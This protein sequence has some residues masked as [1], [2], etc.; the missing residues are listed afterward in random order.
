[1]SKK[2]PDLMEKIV[3]LCKRRG[4]V[5]PGSEIY[6]GFAGTYDYGHYGVL[7]KDHLKDAWIRSMRDQDNIA[8]IDSSIFSSRQVWEA[9]GHVSGFSDPLVIC[10]SCHTRHRADHL[11]EA[12]G[13]QA[14]EKMSEKK[15]NEIFDAH[16]KELKCSVCGKKDFGTVQA[17][18]LM[19]TSTLGKFEEGDQD[20]FL[21][22]ET[23]Q[24]IYI[25]Y[26]NI[27]DT[28]I[29]SI[30]F[31]IAQVGK[32]FRN[33]ISPRQF[34]FR[35]REFEQMEMQYFVNPKDASIEYERWK[36][37]R[38]SYYET[39][40]I[41]KDKLRWKQH[42]NLVF[43]AKDAWDI[44]YEYPFG[45]NELEGL[46]NRGDYDL[47]Q[48]QKFSGVD[49]S[50]FDEETKERFIPHVIEASVGLD[51]TM[52]MVLSDAYDEDEMNGQKRVVLRFA[53]NIAPIRAGV[54]PLLRNKSQLVEKAREVYR[55]LKKEFGNIIFDNNGNIGKRY[56]RQDEIGTPFCITIDFDTLTDDTVTL[57]DRD[58][59]EQKR[60]K[61]ADLKEAIV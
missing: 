58:T 53:K 7:L 36:N 24:G 49:M 19:A 15:L 39:I 2:D 9:S 45:W 60:I 26:K 43:Y 30:P 54:F 37:Q 3:S 6:G 55:E 59:G 5:Y 52:L 51:R 1:M 42:E 28:G 61:V 50:Y 32:V 47:T 4:F 14:D 17:K 25:N 20:L 35:M 22:A 38:M 16:R 10:K 23:A 29:F 13:V 11:L 18:N 21:R 48:H 40:G 33:E 56:R 8:L 31:G 27:L 57:R 44:Q 12:I 46:H 41:K 34:L